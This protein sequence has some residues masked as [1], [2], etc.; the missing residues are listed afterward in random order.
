LIPKPEIDLAALS[1]I[2]RRY[3]QLGDATQILRNGLSINTATCIFET[4]NGRYFA[5][6]YDPLNRDTPSL[7][8]EHSLVAHLR[9]ANFC[10]PLLYAND[11]AETLTW[12]AEFPYALFALARGEDRYGNRGVFDPFD[13]REEARAAGATLARFH[14][15]LHTLPLPEPKPFRGLTAQYQILLAPDPEAAL[16]A[17]LA[18]QPALQQFLAEQP[19]F[20]AITQRVFRHVPVITRGQPNWPLGIIHGD[21]LKRNLFWQ[22]PDVSDVIDFELWNVAPWLYD[23]ALALLPCTFN[24]PELLQG[25]STP[26][27]RDCQAMIAGYHHVRPLHPDERNGLSA[28]LETAR[29]EFYLSAIG[30]ALTHGDPAQ[31]RLFYTLL[32]DTTRWFETH[33]DWHAVLG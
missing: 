27:Q 3:P 33:P 14:L 30:H 11:R 23:L 12:L 18:Q 29:F 10:T 24:W 4:T 19:G 22:G 31:A 25:R 16:Q 13:D 9:A 20:D 17:L 7:M 6:R 26:N 28:M 21:W 1:Q 8:A 5:K 2:V 32:D 15:A